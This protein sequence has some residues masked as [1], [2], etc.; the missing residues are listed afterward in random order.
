MLAS[1]GEPP[2]KPD[3]DRERRY[4]EET[5]P[6]RPIPTFPMR[7]GQRRGEIIPVV[8]RRLVRF[9]RRDWRRIAF[10]LR[11][12]RNLIRVAPSSRA[13]ERFHAVSAPVTAASASPLEECR[14][15]ANW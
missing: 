7:R 10:R 1:V 3:D 14:Q 6:K 4:D 8:M 12:A 2:A 15:C 13:L 11:L 9:L 5:C